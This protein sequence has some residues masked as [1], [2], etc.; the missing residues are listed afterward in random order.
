MRA[1]ALMRGS[2]G[3]NAHVAGALASTP[4]EKPELKVRGGEGDERGSKGRGFAARGEKREGRWVGDIACCP[5][6]CLTFFFSR[7]PACSQL[8]AVA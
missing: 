4:E 5:I 6:L 8:L 2:S 3:F 1:S 7:E